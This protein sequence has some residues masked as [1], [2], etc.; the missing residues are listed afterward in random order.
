[1]TSSDSRIQVLLVEQEA[2]TISLVSL[3]LS[4]IREC[5][6]HIASSG[7]EAL[8]S[9]PEI[10]PD[11]IL[12]AQ[13]LH[14]KDSLE[15]LREI[16]RDYP[17][18]Y[19]IV[20][21]SKK[22]LEVLHAYG[23]AGATD[24][25]SKGPNYIPDLIHSVKSALI[26]IAE[27]QSFELP[28]MA[29][30]NQFVMDEN[31]PDIVFLLDLDGKFLYVN[32]AITEILG[33]EQKDVVGR[34][35]MDFSSES[36][37]QSLRGYL[38]KANALPTF[39]GKL[40]LVNKFGNLE[41]FEVNCTLMEDQTVYGV[42][43]QIERNVP[44]EFEEEEEEQEQA[45]DELLP[46]RLGPYQII[47]LL[48]AGSMGRVYKGFDEQLERNVAIKV[49]SKALAADQEYVERFRREAKVLASISHPNIA[50]IYY[51]DN[52][53]GLPYFCMEYLHGGSLETV[54][55]DNKVLDPETA[56][57]Y[58]MQVALGLSEAEKKGVIHRDIKPSNLM[59][60]ENNRIKIV[61]FG[62]A[63]KAREKQDLDSSIVGTPLYMSPEQLQGGVVDFRCDI[64]ALG[65]SFFRMLYGFIP[66]AG[67]TIGE[68]FSRRLHEDLPSREKLNSSVPSNLY[69]IISVM[70]SR[71]PAK[72]YSKYADLI[73]ALEDS[74]RAI[75]QGTAVLE[76]PIRPAGAVVRMRGTLYDRPLPEILGEIARLGLSGKLTL[77]WIDLVKTLHIKQ[78]KIVAVL[79]NQEGE[80]F[81]ELLQQW[82]QITGKKAREIS[83][84]S[85]DLYM[86]YSSMMSGISP[87]TREKMSR[88]IQELAWR[89]LQGLFS[90]VVGEYIFEDGEFQP[91]LMLEL[92]GSEVVTRG[93]KQWMD[94]ATISRRLMGGDCRIVI[95]PN[96]D[97]LL[98]SIQIAPSDVFLL[99]RFENSIPFQEL[100][101]LS[102]M[103]EESFCRLIYLFLCFGIVSLS[104]LEE[105]PKPSVRKLE[106]TPVPN[107]SKPSQAAKRA[108]A[109]KAAPT[110]LSP[111]EDVASAPRP[112][113]E[114]PVFYY[115]RCAMES[116]KNKNY[117][118]CVE[119]CK[120]ALELR[121]DPDI[122]DLMGQAFSTHQKF[123]HEAMEAF[124]KAIEMDPVNSRI[125][126]NIADLY[127]LSGNYAQALTK[128]QEV[129]RLNS[130]DDHS[131]ERLDEIN[132]KLKK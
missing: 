36:N 56:V 1:M 5:Q 89:I 116:Y 109:P 45:A 42:A 82:H 86:N 84:S 61:D 69:R 24:C 63:K 92:P 119:Y 100:M 33:H 57:S 70:T 77:S 83:E 39:G 78:G 35:L 129:L 58:T 94:F 6:L 71:E 118:A 54:L 68:V 16:S 14:G 125:I 88:S 51:Y 34:T 113:V 105:E 48:G 11:L 21:L 29:R 72:R 65:L 19:L 104:K 30:A 115:Q 12:L 3:C 96:A 111:S 46:A 130:K 97:N 9:I 112:N 99:F 55:S 107:V 60:A 26:R 103:T 20:S 98:K 17:S 2:D 102:G 80:R 22:D 38:S 49:I 114:D 15:V 74:R 123:R 59:L 31:L 121:K 66:F 73:E 10:R 8:M 87:E 101:N 75:L 122:Y 131:L 126:R 120:K 37:H 18:I 40:R 93:V 4:E 62:L 79:S 25:V 110:V 41:R 28:P 53:D 52:L 67:T 64:Y 91:Q 76:E 27:R 124:E 117:W 90:W 85:F 127:Y 106:R 47:T 81:Y 7:E 95:A 23:K 13:G 43:R 108:E 32:R 50:L 44:P 128:Y 132:K